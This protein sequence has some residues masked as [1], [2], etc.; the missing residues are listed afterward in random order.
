MVVEPHILVVDADASAAQVTGAVVTQVAPR[1]H[2]TV[3][4]SLIEGLQR[5]R[6]E[7]PDVLLIDPARQG[8]TVARA[9]QDIKDIHR[10][11]YIIVLASIPTPTLRRSMQQLGVDVYLEKP[12]LLPL[13]IKEMSAALERSNREQSVGVR[14]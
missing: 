7:R 2:I 1:A 6:H 13:F 9:I 8:R 5:M 4:P 3:A 12:V 14:V 11:M 10:G